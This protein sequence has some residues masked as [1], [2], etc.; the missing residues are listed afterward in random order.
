MKF[1]VTLLIVMF[2]SLMACAA[3]PKKDETQYQVNIEIQYNSVSVDEAQKIIAQALKEHSKACT[4]DA[5]AKKVDSSSICI[6]ISD[7]I[8]Y[9]SDSTIDITTT[10]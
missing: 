10:K 5:K 1:I 3:E 8:F 6:G 4:V 2:L 9:S 7:S